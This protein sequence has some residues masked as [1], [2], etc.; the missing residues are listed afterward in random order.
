MLTPIAVIRTCNRRLSRAPAQSGFPFN[1]KGEPRWN[2]RM[3]LHPANPGTRKSSSAKKRLSSSIWAIRVRLQM[4]ERLR[5]LALLNL[6]ID[7]KLRA[8]DLVRLRVRDVCHGD[9]VAAR[10][11]DAAEDATSHAIR[12]HIINARRAAVLDQA[13]RFEIG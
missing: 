4:H 5:E 10:H 11:G 8:C 13:R 3:S 7:S 6:G 1:P 9:R 2:R 12:N